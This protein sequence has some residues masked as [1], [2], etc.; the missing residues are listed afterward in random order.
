MHVCFVLVEMKSQYFG[1]IYGIPY[2][3]LSFALYSNELKV[4]QIEYFLLKVS[5]KLF[6]FPFLTFSILF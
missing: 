5:I 2:D 1:T 3:Y 6:L 4:I